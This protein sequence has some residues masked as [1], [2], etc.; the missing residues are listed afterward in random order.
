MFK[1]LAFTEYLRWR[2][3]HFGSSPAGR[4]LH[5]PRGISELWGNDW[6]VERT[7]SATFVQ[8]F[9]GNIDSLLLGAQGAR[10][11]FQ[12]FARF[13]CGEDIIR[14]EG[15][16]FLSRSLRE[17]SFGA[18]HLPK[19]SGATSPALSQY[20]DKLRTSGIGRVCSDD[21]ARQSFEFF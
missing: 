17:G 15:R 16:R 1:K 2:T 10:S 4:A 19:Q 9:A 8:G 14:V 18:R 3:L 7:S 21:M 5:C 11:T 12:S 13:N 20:F 6:D